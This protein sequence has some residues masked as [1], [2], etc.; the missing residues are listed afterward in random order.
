MAQGRGRRLPQPQVLRSLPALRAHAQGQ[1]RAGLRRPAG[2]DAGAAGGAAAGAGI[3]SE[4]LRLHPRGRISGHQPRA[5]RA[6]APADGEKAQSLRGGRRRPVHLR[7]AR[8]GHQQH[9]GL[10]E[11]FSRREGGQAGAE[12]PLHRQHPRRGQSGHRPQSGPQGEGALDAGRRGREDRAVP[13]AGRARRGGLHR[14]HDAQAHRPRR[15]GGRRGGAVP[16]QC[17]VA[18]A[19]RGL[20]PRR[21]SLSRLRRPEVLRAQESRI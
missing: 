10:R 14:R 13:R 7:L 5:V 4:P 1:Q 16:H 12:L 18:R 17:P 9:S 3:L 20:R 19:G 8:R 11:G 6:G 2:Q 21:H 15:A